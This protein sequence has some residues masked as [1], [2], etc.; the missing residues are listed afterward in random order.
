VRAFSDDDVDDAAARIF[1][2]LYGEFLHQPI[3]AFA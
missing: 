1:G 3:E 2:H